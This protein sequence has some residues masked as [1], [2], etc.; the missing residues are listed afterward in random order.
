MPSVERYT[1]AVITI[2]D[3]ASNGEREDKSGDTLEGLLQKAGFSITDREVV[4]DERQVIAGTLT[5]CT[6]SHNIACIFTTGGTG[7]G[8]RDVTPEAAKDVIERRMPGMEEAMRHESLRQ[9]PFAMLSRQ[10]V[11][12]AKDTLIVTLP[13]SE[14]AVRECFAVIQPVLKH[15]VD[16]LAGETAHKSSNN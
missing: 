2:S 7:V 10:V 9:T 16:L 12:V 1:A 13:G 4:P 6:A 5:R 11:G 3:S 15:V 14:K 8:P